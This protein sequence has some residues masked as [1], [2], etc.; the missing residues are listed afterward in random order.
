MSTQTICPSLQLL[1]DWYLDKLILNDDNGARD[2]CSM[3][4]K[5]ISQTPQEYIPIPSRNPKFVNPEFYLSAPQQEQMRNDEI[6]AKQIRKA[7]FNQLNS[8]RNIPGMVGIRYSRIESYLAKLATGDFLLSRIE[9]I[10]MK[11]AQSFVSSNI[12]QSSREELT[13]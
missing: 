12:N 2:V 7:D 1:R 10:A 13:P 9:F 5:M 11:A 4:N 6:R 8:W 3:G